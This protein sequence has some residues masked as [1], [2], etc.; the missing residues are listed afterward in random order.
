MASSVNGADTDKSP[1]R[2][3]D[4]PSSSVPLRTVTLVSDPN[5]RVLSNGT[6]TPKDSKEVGGPISDASSSRDTSS[7]REMPR[8]IRDGSTSDGLSIDTPRSG[9]YERESSSSLQERK[10]RER[11]RER[12]RERDRE[13]EREDRE[14]DRDDKK[15]RETS[16][17]RNMRRKSRRASPSHQS[18]EDLSGQ[19]TAGAKYDPSLL[20]IFCSSLIF[21][22]LRFFFYCG[23]VR[24]KIVCIE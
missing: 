23:W 8:D 13:R 17:A 18:S 15:D 10:Y 7:T 12:E 9:S 14:R 19:D 1:P 3:R 6:M 21:S 24:N 11:D 22:S 4:T 2:N 16:E 5:F 20:L